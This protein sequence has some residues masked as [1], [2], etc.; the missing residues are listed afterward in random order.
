MAK[1]YPDLKKAASSR[2]RWARISGGFCGSIA[3]M[4]PSG[5]TARIETNSF[6]IPP[7]FELIEQSANLSRQEMFE[8]FN[9][10]IGLVL[11][12]SRQLVGQVKNVLCCCGERAYIIGSVI[13]GDAGYELI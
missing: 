2:K 8:H 6:P 9:M 10:G 5:L 7:S 4:M 3:S 11:V 1:R 13:R 12:I